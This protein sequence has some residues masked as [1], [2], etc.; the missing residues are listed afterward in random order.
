MKIKKRIIKYKK[1]INN[2]KEEIE[3]LKFEKKETINIEKL[4]DDINDNLRN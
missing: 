1:E 2:L 4:L 3:K